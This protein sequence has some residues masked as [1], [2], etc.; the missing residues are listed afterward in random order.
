MVY[1]GNNGIIFGQS[2]Y[3]LVFI[4]IYKGVSYV[5]VVQIWMYNDVVVLMFK[6]VKCDLFIF[7]GWCEVV[8]YMG[9]MELEWLRFG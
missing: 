6:V 2:V 1:F 4:Y 3:L 8:F 9:V 5:N 7:D